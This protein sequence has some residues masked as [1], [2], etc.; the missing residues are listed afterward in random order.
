MLVD[1][2]CHLDFEDFGEDIDEIVARAGA[3]GV[4][5]MVTICTR[6]SR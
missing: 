5:A 2:H 6:L 1:S 3:D 4:G